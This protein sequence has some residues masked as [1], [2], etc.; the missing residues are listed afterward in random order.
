MQIYKLTAAERQAIEAL[1][2]ERSNVLMVVCDLGGEIGCA[3]N[4]V[5][6]DNPIYADY[7]ALI[8]E[9]LDTERFV[10]WTPELL[11]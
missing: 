7:R 8:G 6:L 5:D 3:V 10:E 2:T 9:I 1:N 11:V 4:S